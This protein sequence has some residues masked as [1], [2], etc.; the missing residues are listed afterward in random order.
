MS[1]PV[2]TFFN[3]K[4]G[5]GK[6]SMIYHLSHMFADNGMRVLS[7]DL[8]PQ[9]NLTAAFIDED[10]LEEVF[11]DGSHDKTILGAIGPIKS[12]TGDIAMPYVEPINDNLKVIIGDL[13]L[14][15]FEDHLS[16][17]WPKCLAGDE[18]SFRV[19]SAFWRVLQMAGKDWADVALIDVGPNLGATNRAALIAS[20]YVVIPL[21]PDMF[22]LQGLDNLGPALR[23]W[24][25]DWQD[26]LNRKPQIDFNLPSGKIRPVGY[27][28]L[29]HAI[30]LDRPVKAF[31]KWMAR[32]PKTYAQS[33]L[34]TPSARTVAS[35]ND[36]QCI[37]KLRDYRSL[38]PLAQEARKPMFLL[39][40]ADG[41]LGAHANAVRDV[42]ADFLEVAR[43]IARRTG[44]KM[45]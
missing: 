13:G 9:C 3:N 19:T 15:S 10:R 23:T 32:I 36:P 17:C 4:G 14:S 30:R 28:V 12:G 8:D 40:P 16:E 1:I 44:L 26:R 34:D 27:M 39:K 25:A 5:V 41:A 7:A 35:D 18:R 2:I 29:R 45:E 38:M 20:D 22:S 43:A 33:V 31:E 6:T 42:Y 37:A 11:K 21:G 24:R